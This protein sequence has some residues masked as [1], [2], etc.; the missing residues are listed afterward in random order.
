MT[1]T[2]RIRVMVVDDHPIM[3][4]G[5]REALE[6]EEDL[7]VVALAA[8]GVEAVRAAQEF[9]PGVIVMDVI[10][11]NQDGVD[12]CREIMDL[13]PGMKVLM[14]T[15]STVEDAVLDAIAAGAA[16]FLQKHVGPAELAEA[17]RRVA[18]GRLHIPEQS[19]RRVFEMIRERR[20][21]PSHGGLEKLT[22]LERE[23]LRMFVRGMSYAQIA[24]IRGNRTVSVRNSIY[25]IQEKLGVQSKQ[26]MVVWAVRNGLLDEED[27][28]S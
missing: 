9:E 20:G 5:L 10:M 11:P 28:G 3:R 15:A 21:I 27:S 17:V 23:I 24:E 25:R 12:A 16:G 18:Q 6:S 19:M 7:E 1:S 22:D 14:L 4:N 8:D 2:E 26:E 13:L